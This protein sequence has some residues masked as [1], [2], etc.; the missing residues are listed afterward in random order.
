MRQRNTLALALA[1]SLTTACSLAPGVHM[2]DAEVTER[3]HEQ[4]DANFQIQVVSPWLIQKFA[5][6]LPG[7][8]GGAAGRSERRAAARTTSTRWPPT[9]SSRSS[10]GTT[11]S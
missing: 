9:T 4:G 11:R 7:R 3:A 1:A 8:G 2:K 6:E 10:S 5:K